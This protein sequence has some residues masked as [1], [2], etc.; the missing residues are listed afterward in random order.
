MKISEK[1]KTIVNAIDIDR[2]SYQFGGDISIEAMKI[3][4]VNFAY[5][6]YFEGSKKNDNDELV[7][8]LTGL[9]KIATRGI[10]WKFYQ[11]LCESNVSKG[12]YHPDFLITSILQDGKMEVKY[13][14]NTLIIS[15]EIHL[16]SK[17]Y[18]SQIGD[19]VP[20]LSPPNRIKNEF[21][22]AFNNTIEYYDPIKEEKFD[23]QSA[24]IYFNFSPLAAIKA[25][26]LLSCK[27]N[28]E[29]IIFNFQALHN[30]LKYDR[31]F[32]AMLKFDKDNYDLIRFYVSNFYKENSHLFNQAIPFFTKRLAPG[33]SFSERS[34]LRFDNQESFGINR[35][36]LLID[37][38][39]SSD[40]YS[41]KLKIKSICDYFDNLGL[42][43]DKLYLNSDSEDIYKPL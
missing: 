35:C 40:N 19:L 14:D 32:V 43:I 11:Q 17:Y 30:P 22:V 36:R 38:I 33:V 37:A 9:K 12:W 13:D 5:K 23:N 20:V 18:N 24:Y 3:N 34:N 27:L 21:Y 16:D 25:L 1:L 4:S 15:E 6:K 8:L 26:Q 42:T 7:D 10:D 29:Q 39:T 31:Y 2:S 41:F 28:Q